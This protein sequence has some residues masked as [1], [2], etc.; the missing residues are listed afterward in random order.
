MPA[1]KKSAK[2]NL[3]AISTPNRNESHLQTDVTF[4]NQS[5]A[6]ISAIPVLSPPTPTRKKSSKKTVN[7]ASFQWGQKK[8]GRDLF[9]EIASNEPSAKTSRS[10]NRSKTKPAKFR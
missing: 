8:R 4:M 2:F 7:E 5:E 3:R 9:D 6:D 1:I 10:S